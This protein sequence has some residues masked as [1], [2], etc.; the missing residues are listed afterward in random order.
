[1]I[2]GRRSLSKAEVCQKWLALAQQFDF[3]RTGN[4]ESSQYTY[5]RSLRADRESTL[6]IVLS[7]KIIVRYKAYP[8]GNVRPWCF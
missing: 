8:Y 4:L 7:T 5:D 6:L 3:L 1:M 2:R